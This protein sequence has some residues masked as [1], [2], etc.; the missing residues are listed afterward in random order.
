MSELFALLVGLCS[1]NYCSFGV[2]HNTEGDWLAVRVY[3]KSAEIIELEYFD[4]EALEF[5]TVKGWD[6]DGE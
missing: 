4:I 6:R 2:V 5:D 3:D 1:L